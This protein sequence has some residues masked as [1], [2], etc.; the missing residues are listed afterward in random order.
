MALSIQGP[1]ID[2]VELRLLD[3]NLGLVKVI[4]GPALILN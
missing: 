2:L 1:N 4:T 3:L